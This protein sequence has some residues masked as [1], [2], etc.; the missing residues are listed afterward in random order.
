[1][2]TKPEK[3][4]S[5][6]GFAVKAGKVL[7]GIDAIEN[8]R[9]R[10]YL[11]LYGYDLGENTLNKLISVAQYRKVPLIRTGKPMNELVFREG[12]KIVGISDRQM[13][14]AMKKYVNENF[15]LIAP[16]VN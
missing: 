12:V 5:L 2:D 11:I 4:E 16:E 13:A 1:M 9:S 10:V 8:L 14:K 3:I 7:Y 6:L 15:I